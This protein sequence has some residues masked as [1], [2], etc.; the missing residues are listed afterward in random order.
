MS[1]VI[2]NLVG[3]IK[4]A[5]KKLAT[6]KTFD[7]VKRIFKF[8]V[9]VTSMA[10]W[11]KYYR[12]RPHDS[13]P[14]LPEMTPLLGHTLHG[15]HWGNMTKHVYGLVK[16][17][18]FP[19][20]I[21]GTAYIPYY[22]VLLLDPELVKFVFDKQFNK[23]EKGEKISTEMHELLGDGIFTSDP[24]DWKF[25]RKVASRMFSMRNLK[26][27][28]FDCTINHTKKV[29]A[30]IEEQGI[31]MNNINIYD[32]LGRFTLDA[33]TDI[34]FGTTCDSLSSY[35]SKH[36]FAEAFDTLIEAMAKR[37]LIPPSIWKFEKIFNIGNERIIHKNIQI[38]N[39]FAGQVL[40]SRQTSLAGI[41]D[42]SGHSYNDIIS[43]FIK[44]EKKIK[45][46]KNNNEKLTRQELKDIAMNMII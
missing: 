30:K 43:L 34:A 17:A 10:I 31:D 13:I 16:K 29:I 24:P 3:I 23:F 32:M 2:R 12:A 9:A 45:N 28:M 6:V 44:H 1:Q 4:L 20:A 42:E 36:P 26:D 18:D 37:H 25:H 22:I 38:I 19:K 15:R 8:I 41:T 27:Y 7:D 21:A 46:T 5:F 39:E 35:P 40:D 14:M 11:Y 33:F